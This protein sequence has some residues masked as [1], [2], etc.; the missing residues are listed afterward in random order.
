MSAAAGRQRIAAQAALLAALAALGLLVAWH[1]NGYVQQ[2]LFNMALYVLLATGWNVIGGMT[3]YVSFGQVSFFGLGAYVAAIGVLHFDL[4]WATAAVLAAL[5]A[6]C[7]AIPLGLVMLRLSGIF[8]A[9]GMFGLARILQ[10]AANALNV[11]GGPMGTTVPAADT[12]ALP[13]AAAVLLASAAVIAV[14][15]IMRGRLGLRLMAIRDDPVATEAAGVNVWRCKVVAFCIGAGL[16][17]IGGALYVWNVGYLDPNSAFAGTIELQ[18]V[19]MVLA[20]GIGTVWGPVVGGILVSLLGTALWA[21][22]PME[23]QI[24]LGAL[25]ILIAVALPGGLVSLLRRFGWARRPPIWGPPRLSPAP[26]RPAAAALAAAAPVLACRRLGKRFGG[27][28]AVDG[29]DLHVLPGEVLAVIGP[30]GAGKSTLFDLLSGF[31][32][33]SAGQ[34]AYAGRPIADTRPYVLARHGIA[35]TFQTSRLFPSLTVWETV[36]LAASIRH[37]HRADAIGATT[38]LLRSVGLLE[39]WARLPE[40]LPPGRLRLLEIARALALE[41]R[42]LLLDEAMAGMTAQEIAS[43]HQALRAATAGGCAIV[44]IE[45]VLPAIAPLAVRA[46]V[47]DFGRTIAEGAPGVVLRDPAVIAAY[48]GTD[49]AGLDAA[50]A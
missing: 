7:L 24:V 11:T 28:V 32:R 42:V 26:P 29:V 6:T 15:W 2:L 39:D 10:I 41:P 17:A 4:S 13:A 47:L 50:H 20:G 30:N 40:G 22:F 33:P 1:G 35:R 3:G 31:A 34:V 19:L 25:T 9:L 16:A 38:R 45:H 23:Q 12:P 27:V 36:L 5:A 18:T 14:A 37:R 21:R 8:F 49:E 44:A 48:L 46:Q 43:V